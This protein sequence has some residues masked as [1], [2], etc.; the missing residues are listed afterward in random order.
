MLRD[1]SK[2][3]ACV[4]VLAVALLGAPAAA[5]AQTDYVGRDPVTVERDAA[6]PQARVLGR[7]VT[8]SLPIPITGGDVA[9]LTLVGVGAIGAGA[10][11][12]RRGRRAPR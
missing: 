1:V 9:G 5:V 12:V 7:T 3:R 8:R 6:Q 10:F 2:A 11:L 4:V